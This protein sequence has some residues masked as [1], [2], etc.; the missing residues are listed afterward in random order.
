MKRRN[1]GFGYQRIADELSLVFDSEI[2]K[3]IVRH[4]LA[5]HYRPKPGSGRLSWLMFM[6]HSKDSLWSM[7]LFRCESLILKTHW[8][9]VVMDQCTRQATSLNNYQWIS[10]CRGLFRLPIAA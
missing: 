6:G 2:D 9:M 5:N 4:L 8:V 10:H 1:P 7:D 3:D